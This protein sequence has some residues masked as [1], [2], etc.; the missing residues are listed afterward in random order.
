[1]KNFKIILD[2]KKL[3]QLWIPKGMANGYLVLE[4]NTIVNY[5][6]SNYFSK[7]H[8]S[9]LNIFDKQLKIKLPISKKKIIIS[10]KDKSLQFYSKN[11]LYF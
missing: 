9:G 10:K 5:K 3:K 2:S 11:E 6:V 4:K 8:D 7:K 1:M